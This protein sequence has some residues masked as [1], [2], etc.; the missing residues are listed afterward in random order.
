M[1][2]RDIENEKQ[3]YIRLIKQCS[4]DVFREP[5]ANMPIDKFRRCSYYKSALGEVLIMLER[6]SFSP[7]VTLEKIACETYIMAHGDETFEIM[8]NVAMWMID[9][10]SALMNKDKEEIDAEDQ[11]KITDDMY[12]KSMEAEWP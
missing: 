7:I 1:T 8:F 6:S 9:I 5:K 2:L 11:Y 12:R 4:Y 10:L 3:Y